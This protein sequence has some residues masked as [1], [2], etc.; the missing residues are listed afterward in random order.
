[1]AMMISVDDVCDILWDHHLHLGKGLTPWVIV[2]EVI[3]ALVTSEKIVEGCD[4]CMMAC[5]GYWVQ[6]PDRENHWHCSQCGAVQGMACLAMKYC[7]E[8]GAKMEDHKDATD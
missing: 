3:E 5:H 4:D 7:P 8:C 1:M 2:D 6:E